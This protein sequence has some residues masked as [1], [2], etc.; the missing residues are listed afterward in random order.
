MYIY[1]G[2]LT[3]C[4]F[5]DS[6]VLGDK[7]RLLQQPKDQHS[8]NPELVEQGEGRRERSHSVLV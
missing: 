1:S 5:I 6:T 2:E 4:P 3:I 7:E 8:A